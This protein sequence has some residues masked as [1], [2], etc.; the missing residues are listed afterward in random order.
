MAFGLLAHA[1]TPVVAQ[2]VQI[3]REILDSQ[4]RLEEL[5]QERSL[6]QGELTN[7]DGRV[8]NASSELSNVERQ[9]STSRS[10]VAEMD[11]Q[12]EAVGSEIE[13]TSRDIIGSLGGQEAASTIPQAAIAN[14]RASLIR[15][16]TA[17]DA[18]AL[19]APR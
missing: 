4:R 5:R 2:V 16:V 18:R 15:L 1:P 11:F 6:L 12:V 7:I 14:L 10:A 9:L 3:R 13:T 19:V 17:L 8:R